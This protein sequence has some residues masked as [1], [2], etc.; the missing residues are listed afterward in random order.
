MSRKHTAPTIRPVAPPDT[1]LTG[2]PIG[3]DMCAP[4]DGRARLLFGASTHV[5]VSAV[6][7]G[8]RVSWGLSGGVVLARFDTNRWL[9]LKLGG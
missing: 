7:C 6:M 5:F 3:A 9:E 4:V 8:G 1:D 2:A